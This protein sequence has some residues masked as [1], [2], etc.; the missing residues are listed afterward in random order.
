[1]V[2]GFSRSG[3]GTDEFLQLVIDLVAGDTSGIQSLNALEQGFLKAGEA[4]KKFQADLAKL[5]AQF[6][7]VSKSAKSSFDTF[8]SSGTPAM[9]QDLQG[10]T[11]DLSGVIRRN[12]DLALSNKSAKD[13]FQSF[14]Q[15]GLA[16]FNEHLERSSRGISSWL[17][18]AANIHGVFSNLQG[19]M[20]NMNPAAQVLGQSIQEIGFGLMGIAQGGPGAVLGVANIGAAAFK[21]FTDLGQASGQFYNEMR[22]G[23]AVMGMTEQQTYTLRTAM[24]LSGANVGQLQIFI[25]RLTKA[26]E[27]LATGTDNVASRAL[28]KLD[29]AIVDS[30]GNLR[31]SYD[32]LIDV[33]RAL[34]GVSNEQER[35]ALTGELAGMR[36]RE[37]NAL[38]RDFNTT[39]PIAQ[40]LLAEHADLFV[41]LEK[42]Q[43]AYNKQQAE[44][45]LQWQEL[46]TKAG[47]PYINMLEAINKKIDGMTTSM[48]YLP[49]I[50]TLAGGAMY[51]AFLPVSLLFENIGRGLDYISGRWGAGAQASSSYNASLVGSYP[52]T[53][54][55]FYAQARKGPNTVIDPDRLRDINNTRFG[56]GW[57]LD[58]SEAG[59]A[60][61]DPDKFKPK[62]GSGPA[63]GYS[64]LMAQQLNTPAA[65]AAFDEFTSLALPKDF[66]LEAN[67]GK[68]AINAWTMANKEWDEVLQK[69][70]LEELKTKVAITDLRLAGDHTSQTFLDLQARLTGLGEAETYLDMKRH[71]A[72]DGYSADIEALR[73]SMQ[74]AR[75]VTRALV[76]DIQGPSTARGRSQLA[77][78]AVGN[79]FMQ[80]VVHAGSG[81]GVLNI[82]NSVIT[83]GD[84]DAWFAARQARYQRT[85]RTL[86][87]S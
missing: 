9:R 20:T 75:Q 76:I 72:L 47:P 49:S 4:E 48:G 51:N 58:P 38:M 45:K 67:K 77:K 33:Q 59:S 55:E 61:Y 40:Q 78:E 63:T 71:I 65:K 46:A 10:I 24:E 12:Q 16:P 41:D 23:A 15:Q 66:V 73:Q 44:M 52:L 8:V 31:S 84:I 69:V 19:A 85:G 43:L 64:G 27:D 32:L 74:N 22:T 83:T 80:Q 7:A 37:V 6:D 1:M 26:Q 18:N 56:K 79:D 70:R 5:N 42:K 81:S 86:V 14:A 36:S 11:N 62:G 13:S 2:S 34:S 29:V 60:P 25:Q 57:D 54:D 28:K 68:A 3:G 30:N 17:V 87:G 53:E 82:T 39:L 35:N 50:S 21:T